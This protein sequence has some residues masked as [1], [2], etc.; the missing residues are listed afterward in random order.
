LQGLASRAGLDFDVLALPWGSALDSARIRATLGTRGGYAWLWSVATETSTG[1]ANNIDNLKSIAREFDVRLCLDCMSAIGMVPLDLSDVYLASASSGKGLA[2]VA[3]IALVF[4]QED[5][6]IN[7]DAPA[8]L[9]LALHLRD[10]EV[11]FTMPSPLLAALHA[12]LGELIAEGSTRYAR[13]ERHD[14]WLRRAVAHTFRLIGE[15]SRASGVITL[16]LESSM[17]SQLLGERLREHGVEIGFESAY[18]RERRWIQCA[19]MGRYSELTLRR[20]PQLMQSSRQAPGSNAL[21][22]TPAALSHFAFG[23]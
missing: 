22:K 19:L 10:C 4:A 7:H 13:I 20:L 11:S 6:A 1:V 23:E 2:S 9:D 15:H 17:D 16:A 14:Q 21:D 3:G 18:L 12:S 5:P 8:S